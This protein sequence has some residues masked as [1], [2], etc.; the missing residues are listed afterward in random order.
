MVAKPAAPKP[1]SSSTRNTGTKPITKPARVRAAKEREEEI[2]ETAS[3]TVAGHQVALPLTSAVQLDQ[4]GKAAG[5]A[6]A[7]GQRIWGAARQQL[8]RPGAGADSALVARARNTGTAGYNAA[9]HV[10]TLDG[11]LV[12]DDLSHDGPIVRAVIAAADGIQ[13]DIRLVA[14]KTADR[15]AASA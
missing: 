15:V 7:E 12:A 13:V 1:G 9:E 10:L 14:S 4:P 5:D 8:L 2:T 3:E 11:D 6:L